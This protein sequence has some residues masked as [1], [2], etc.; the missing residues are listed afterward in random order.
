MTT[1]FGSYRNDCGEP[2]RLTVVKPPNWHSSDRRTAIVWIH[3]GAWKHGALELVLPN[4]RYGARQGMVSFGVQYRLI[5]AA[6]DGRERATLE[7]CIA[8][9]RAALRH[10]GEFAERYGVHPERIVVAGD[11]AGG[12]LAACLGLQYEEAG[13]RPAA[14][15]NCNGISDLTRK[16]KHALIEDEGAYPT[17]Q[18]W[19]GLHERAKRLSPIHHVTGGRPPMLLIHGLEDRVV[20][21]EDSVALYEAMLKAGNEAQLLLLPNKKH[22]FILYDYLYALDEVDETM[23]LIDSY[24]QSLALLGGEV[25]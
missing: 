19:F 4:C 11:S 10:I 23:R 20:E 3:G 13:V 6:A 2:L 14:I 9:C 25:E 16:W 15:I 8:D 22:A 17:E 24:L 12:Y 7:D 21:P 18:Q 5:G 1:E